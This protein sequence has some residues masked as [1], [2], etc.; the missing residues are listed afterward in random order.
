MTEQAVQIIITVKLGDESRE[1]TQSMAIE[2]L[3]GG[4]ASLLS[5]PF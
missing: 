5:F 3:E 4:I 2:E 1:V